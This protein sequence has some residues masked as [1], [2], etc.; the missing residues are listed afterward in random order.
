MV[1]HLF[2]VPFCYYEGCMAV[3]IHKEQD[4]LLVIS[5]SGAFTEADLEACQKETI[6]LIEE[7]GRIKTLILLSN[8]QGWEK[9]KAWGSVAFMNTFGEKVD[10]MAFVGDM[11]WR[12]EV[13][14]FTGK[15]LR[16][17]QIEY[18]DAAAESLARDWLKDS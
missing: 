3:K 13:F 10:K 8:F 18:F 6:Q 11:K 9:S 7:A 4:A 1:G 2:A 5:V 12:D 17:T 14:S 16:P 15:D